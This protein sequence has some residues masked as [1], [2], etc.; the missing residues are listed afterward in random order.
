MSATFELHRIVQPLTVWR[1]LPSQSVIGPLDV[2]SVE[3]SSLS[4]LTALEAEEWL[5]HRED[6]TRGGVSHKSLALPE[7]D[8]VE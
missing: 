4:V 6:Y 7:H 8:I 2:W 1:D 3:P 5:T